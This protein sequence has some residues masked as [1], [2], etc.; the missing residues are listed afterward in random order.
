[1]REPRRAS[2]RVTQLRGLRRLARFLLI[3]LRN[4]SR[5]KHGGFGQVA[6]TDPQGGF[7][8]TTLVI[9]LALTTSACG[10]LEQLQINGPARLDPNKVYLNRLDVVRV[11]PR[12][13]NRFACLNSPLVCNQ[14]GIEFECSCP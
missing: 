9:A 6:R 12:E 3:R 14:R 10:F 1:M 8:R 4:R 11:R 5:P 13:T 2:P 7:V